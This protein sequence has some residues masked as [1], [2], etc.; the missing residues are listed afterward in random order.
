[1]VF[2]FSAG[3][4]PVWFP[5]LEM[6][7]LPY[8]IFHT[9]TFVREVDYFFPFA[10]CCTS[11]PVLPNFL[12]GGILQDTDPAFAEGRMQFEREAPNAASNPLQIGLSLSGWVLRGLRPFGKSEIQRCPYFI[13]RQ[14]GMCG[15]WRYR[16]SICSTWFCKYEHGAN[17]RQFWNS[18]RQLLIVL[19]NALSVWAASKLG[20]SATSSFLNQLPWNQWQGREREFYIACFELVSALSWTQI[21]EIGGNEAKTWI[22]AVQSAFD[23]LNS[24]S[25]PEK[26]VSG[27]YKRYV[28]P[29]ETSRFVSYNEYDLIDLPNSIAEL[30][31]RFDGRPW[32]NVLKSI[33][34]ETGIDVDASLV[35]KLWEYSILVEAQ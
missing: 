21:L 18:V 2:L 30:L 13:P 1:V 7:D 9:S 17:S 16:E 19:Q 12:V 8:G 29:N 15:I 25:I 26:L 24:E 3:E 28:L 14:G 23:L 5:R 20:I 31:P 4:T 33:K 27:N 6:L 35:R 22:D 11:M 34:E 10:K 32:M